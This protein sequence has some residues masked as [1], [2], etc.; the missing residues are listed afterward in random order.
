MVVVE[1]E[2]LVGRAWEWGRNFKVLQQSM[3]VRSA[4]LKIM[5]YVL[6]NSLSLKTKKCGEEGNRT[7][8]NICW[9]N[10]ILAQSHCSVC[11]H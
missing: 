7:T 9:F 8:E 1:R 11:F 10:Q 4:S 6:P 2:T 5:A 3:Q